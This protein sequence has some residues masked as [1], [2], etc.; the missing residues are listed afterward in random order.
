MLLLHG[1]PPCRHGREGRA[2]PPY[3][4]ARAAGHHSLPA[5]SLL[6]DLQQPRMATPPMELRRWGCSSHASLPSLTLLLHCF[7]LCRP[8]RA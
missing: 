8:Q 4:V 3:R 2:R 7:V 5:S 6:E 1:L